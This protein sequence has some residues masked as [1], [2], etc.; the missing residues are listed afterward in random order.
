LVLVIVL[1][2]ALWTEEVYPIGTVFPVQLF[3]PA[4][5]ILMLA[6]IHVLDNGAG[7]ALKTLRPVLTAT[8]EE[9]DLLRYRL[10]TL[11]AV[12]TLL[13]SLA[14][15]AVIFLLGVITGDRESSLEALATSPLAANL[16][17]VVYY[18]GWWS[19]GAFAYHTL[20]Q[21]QVINRI[22]TRHTRVSL[23][24]MSPLY[25]FSGVTA[26][27][28]ATLAIVTYGW[29]A[30]NPDNL[31]D[32]VS[33]VVIFLITVLALAAFAW[34]LLGARRLL[35]AE[36]S[37]KL[38][39]VSRRLDAVYSKMH[40]HIDSGEIEALEDLTKVV[41]ALETERD[42]LQAISTW[43]WQPETLRFLATAL[44]LPLLLW[45]LQFILQRFL[46]A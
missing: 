16:L 37:Q 26:L 40:E 44:L 2:A 32:P 9:V 23:F 5:I 30:L 36:K 1:V 45:I 35:F 24:A 10:T 6:M 12:P 3:M 41:S 34:P 29:T 7:A 13:A 8:E 19:F 42:M 21:L 39:Q 38:D 33:I 14:M 28:A 17:L 22:Y 31:D 18:V 11:P 4:M 25:A 46:G 27:T 15:V 43:P 20:H